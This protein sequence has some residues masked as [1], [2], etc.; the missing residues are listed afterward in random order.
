MLT[1]TFGISAFAQQRTVKFTGRDRTNQYRV[2][3]DRVEIFNLDQL[4]EEVIYWPDTTLMMGTVGIEDLEY[5]TSVQLLCNVPN[6]FNGNTEFAL[7]LPEGRDVRLELFDVTGKFVVGEDFSALPA[8]THLF[9]ATLMSPQTYLLSATVKDGRMTLKM[10]NEGHG[11]VNAIRYIG[12]TD[13]DGDLTVQLKKDRATGLYPFTVGDEMQY[14]GY[15]TIDGAEMASSTVNQNQFND[16]I[17]PLLFDVTVPVVNTIDV[18]SVSANS[19]TISCQVIDECG[20]NVTSRGVCW[21]QLYSPTI[22]G[23]HTIDGG[24]SGIY[25]SDITGLAPNTSY[26]VRAYATN[27]VGTSYGEQMS[28]MTDCDVVTV[29]VSGDSIIDYGQSTTLMASGATSYHWS[30]GANTANITVSPTSTTTYIVTGTNQY[31]CTATATKTVTVNPIL[32]TVNTINVSD[33]TSTTVSCGGHVVSEGGAVVTAYGVCWS[34]SHNPTINNTHTN[35]GS[36]SG[37]FSSLIMGLTPNTTYYVRAYATNSAGTAYGEEVTFT[38]ACN[39]V[40]I[41]IIG[42][43]SVNYGQSVTLTAHGASS[44]QWNTGTSSSSITVSP[45]STINYTVTGTDSYGCTATATIT[46]TVIPIIPTVTTSVVSDITANSASCGG[47]VTSN[48]GS[49]V[50]ARGVCWST[51][52][53]P[54][55][56]DS[57][58]TNGSGNGSFS[59]YI[60]GLMPNTTYYVRAYATNSVGTGYGVQK[61]FTTNCNTVNLSI[62]GT[63]TIDYGESTTLTA[64]GASSYQWSTNATTASITVSPTTTTTYTVTG[65]NSYGCTATASATVTVNSLVPTVTTN[66][67]SSITTNSASCGGNVTSN[68]GANVTA[69]GVCWSTSQNPTVSGSHTTDGSGTGSFTSSLT[70]LTPNTTYYVRAYATNSKGTGYGEQKSFTTLTSGT[71]VIDEKSCPAAPTVTDHEGNV[72]ATVQIGN[73]C[74]MRDNLRTTT[75]P[76]TGTYLIPASGTGYTFTGKQARW[77]NN[78]SATYAPQNYG[79][80]YNWNAAVDTFN[81]AYGETS[82]NTSSNNA[83]SVTFSG[84]RRGICPAGWH[85]PSDAEWNTM[86]ATVSGSD[87]LTS[88]ETTTGWRGNHAGKLAG[89]DN[90]TSSTTSGASGDYGNADRNVSGFSAVPAGDC[91]GSSFNRAGFSADFWSSTQ[92]GS[93][94]AY[95]R[96]LGYDNAN[97]G[98]LTYYKLYGYSVR[99]LRDETGTVVIDEKSCPA[100]PTVT[101]HEGNVYA[102][103]QIGDQCWMRD[104]LRT[105]TSP[106]TGT[107]LIPASGTG[108]TFTG[109]QA[110]WYNNDSTTYAPMNYGLLYNWNAAVDTF[111][112]AYGETNISSNNAVSVT[113][114]GHRRGICP[115][116]WHLPS[117]AEWTQLTDYVSSQSEYTCSGNSSYIAKALASTEGWN[118]ST[119]SCAVG[120]NQGSNNATGFSAVPAGYCNGSSF[121]G[122]G[123]S[124]HFWSST[125]VNSGDAWYRYLYY[126][127]A[128]A[129]RYYNGKYNGFSVRCLRDETGTVVIDEKSCPAAPTVTDHEGNVYATVQIGNQCW[130]RDNLRTT[131]SPS[132]GTYLIPASSTGYTFTG[133]QACWYNNDSATYAPQ[134]YGLLYN[135]NAAVDTFNTAYGETSVNTSSNNAVSVTFSGHRRGICPAGWHL[136]SDAEW[137][138]L[139]DYVSSQSEY[140]CSG[141]SSNIAKALAS[142]EGWNTSTNSCAVGNNQG[143]NNATGFSAVPAGYCSGSSFNGAGDR[144]YFWSSAQNSSNSAWNRYLHYNNAYVLRYNDYKSNGFSV[145]CL[146]D[147]TGTVV[148]DEKSC[149]AAPTVTDHEGNVYATVQI[150]NQ[151]WMRDNLRTTTSPS[152]GTYLIPASGTG[153]TFT[154]KQARWYNNDSATYAPQN[155]G[156]LYNWNAAVDTFNTAY[157]ETSVNTSSNNAVSVTFSGHRRGICPAGWHLPSDAEWTQLTDYVSS[158]S[159]YTCSGDSS[160]IA[161]A[162]AS[163]EG[164]NTSTNSCAVGNNQ[165][166]NNATGFSAVPAGY[167]SGSSFNGAGDRAYFWSSSQISSN[168]AYGRYLNSS[169]ASVV[170]DGNDKNYGRSV[171]CLRDSGGSG[172]SSATLPTVTTNTVS[173][174]TPTTATSGGNIIADGGAS[175]T[176]RGVCWSTSQNPTVNGSHT[177]DGSGMGSFSSSISGLTAN[178]T[179]YVRAYATNSAGTAYGETVAFTTLSAGGTAIIDAK[180]CPAAP[181]VT[182][183][184]GNVYATV[185]I[186]DQC[187]MRDN[188][189]TTTSPSTGTYLI[190]A[191]GTGYTCTGKQAFWYNNDSATY[192]PQNYGLL[193]NWNAAV[194]TFNTA[195][196]ETSVN[197]SSN[198]AVSV[199]FSGHRRGICP[200]GWHLPSDAEWNTMEA[201]VS[202]SDWLTSYETTT[203]W[204]GNH[205]GKLAGGDNWTSSTTSGASG[206]YG[207]AD[208]NVSGFSAVPAGHCNGSS[209]NY[210][211][212]SANFWSATQLA[213]DPNYAYNRFLYCSNANVGRS[214]SPKRNGRSVRCLRDETGTVVIDEKSCP[215][216]PTVTDHEGNVYATVQIGN[217][218]W[219]RDNLRTTT[220]PSTGTYLIP[221]ANADY[222]NTGKQA[223]WYNNDSTTYAPMNYGLLYNWNAAVDTF[224]TMYGEISVNISSSYAVSVI[225]SGYRRGICPVGWHLPSDAEWNTLEAT[226]SG[227]DWQTSYENSTGYRGTHAGKLAGGDNWTTS[228]TSGAP[229]DYGNITRNVSSFSAVPAGSCTGSSFFNEGNNADFWS[230]TQYIDDYAHNRFLYSTSA[231][232]NRYVGNKGGGR[233]V[234][235]LRDETGTAVIDEKSCP[236][237]PTVT[238]HE[239]NVYA[240]VQIGDQ[241]WMRDNLRT[242]TSPSTGTYLIPAAGT[243]ETYTGKQARWYNNDS[244]TYAPMNYGLLYNWNAAVDT[245]N[246]AYGETSVNSNSSNAVSVTFTGHRRGICPA[247]WHLPS[248]AEWTTLTDYVSS[249]SEFQCG[250]N[251]SYIAKAL[252]ST[253]G[254]GTNTNNCT[255][256]NDPSTNNATGF[257]AVPAGSCFGSSFSSAGYYA[258]FWSSTQNGS[259]LASIRSLS[260]DNARVAWGPNDERAGRSVRCLRDETSGGGGTAATLPTVTTGSVSD[261]TAMSATCGG[262]VTVDGGASVTARGVCW[263]TSQNPTVSNSHTTDGSGTGSFSS[264]ISG[265]TANTTYYVRAYATNSAGTAY[266]ETVAFTTLSAGGTAIIDAKSCPEAQTVTDHEGNV[267]ATVQIGNQCWMRDNLRTTT[268]PST[269]T[270]IIPAANANYTYTGK[271]AFWYNNDSATYAPQ[272]YGLLYN[273]NA[274]VDT[275]NTAY[276]ETSVN[277]NSS[278]AVSVTFN[279]HRRGI[280]PAGWHLP[281]DAE[282]TAME[283]TQTS[284]DVTGTGWRGDHAGKLAGEGWS[285]ST[286]AGAPGN[287]SDP[288]HNASGFSAVP[289]GNCG[290]SSFYSAGYDA[291]FWSSPQDGSYYAY[292]AYHRYLYCNSAYVLRSSN[293]KANGFSVRCLRD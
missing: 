268:S 167:C 248:N 74:W 277:S 245:F 35:D 252:A 283:Q 105:T 293:L 26:Y 6:P 73:Q 191:T 160:N 152:T 214:S 135:W 70:G 242:T 166:S 205:A 145:R 87:W 138:Q 136:P 134:N 50:T 270:Y 131:T 151:C 104:N 47:N 229:G 231:G 129:G 123:L 209:F 14:T 60:T 25:F 20:A 66:N 273:W 156:L 9:E 12:M 71:A 115:A 92:D 250:G 194:D 88:Y 223:R 185:Q 154:G 117:D 287:A 78:D 193:Y 286:T 212:F 208:R 147:E 77:Y 68:G 258:Y 46:V 57:H 19:A 180:S 133:K 108:Y 203:G 226:V 90:W 254:W 155:Y 195:Y 62:T 274:A 249:Q 30:T 289:A 265:L 149:P 260:Y 106:S 95:D 198:N 126:L 246:T 267:Y 100:A 210:A 263:S 75:S 215:A 101:D 112:T 36:G 241:C 27:I 257:S 247:G 125:Q 175:V 211:G 15:T 279:G 222:T 165:G 202:G 251:S 217:Q 128:N 271:Q 285:S 227:S 282:W 179:Y 132:T 76:S 172:G 40:T 41:N 113:F 65:T 253:E 234:R 280:C 94:H 24:G 272:N 109:K 170:R 114:S 58:T 171:R 54:T 140:T 52:Q 18:T 34:T 17:I 122:V 291:Y 188:L 3:L 150:G 45:T 102:T 204:R 44:Y 64:S 130:M 55:V 2:Q 89:G 173:N 228:T 266:G 232:V 161:K 182:D 276:G 143:S 184:E 4:W 264:S 141:D 91:D 81:T 192:A 275:F 181:T 219:M 16:E 21:S 10:I 174:I 107:Y 127:N 224:N 80:L 243:Y 31:N 178:T 244:A 8:G 189:R 159:E 79:L 233:S 137:T 96:G 103:V 39:T 235:C 118:T 61:T 238:D 162:L 69:R 213:S 110:R 148:I 82:V 288:A 43:T 237:A 63:T 86:E 218:C 236:S 199:T 183:H 53:N 163:T 206:D 83:V 239:G 33:I 230:V 177:A 201:T 186:G 292:Y 32:P 144:A 278:N 225:F 42:T 269:G 139:T 116:G 28:F 153:Y 168:Y 5:Q 59:S 176:A 56:S 1:V 85:L 197:T 262:E 158:Q 99:C 48:G 7:C 49:I 22:N 142:T 187:W 51:S 67:V 256:G 259:S 164:W 284:M 196:G 29:I 97:V 157:G 290:G 255:V 121:G 124:A 216:A 207:N 200:A 111:N 119:N 281:S 220:S 11:G 169:L 37:P 84:H 221:A 93:R 120:N 240:T 72:Y 190:P 261:V 98:R 38:T 146:R 23:D 13:L